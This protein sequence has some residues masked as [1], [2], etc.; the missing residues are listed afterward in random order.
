MKTD[1][2]DDGS[3]FIS[4]DSSNFRKGQLS[5][6]P[7]EAEA[8]GLRYAVKK[9]NHFLSACPEV[10]VLTDCKTLG[11]THAKPLESIVNK[12]VQKMFLDIQHI[13]LKFQHIEGIKN[14][15]ADFCSRHPRNAFEAS[16]EDES[17]VSLRLGVRTVRAQEQNLEPV[18]P[19]LEKMADNAL[20]DMNYQRRSHYMNLTKMEN[21]S[22]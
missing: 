3:V 21:Y 9:E 12:R 15:V 19:R 10:L 18:D 14:C 6:C 16:T 8:A 1:N 4:M 13:N 2:P 22:S 7:F 17:D 11:S 5:L 20:L